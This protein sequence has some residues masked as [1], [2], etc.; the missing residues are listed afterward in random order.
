M[1]P[2]TRVFHDPLV[3]WNVEGFNPQVCFYIVYALN[4]FLHNDT[5]WHPWETSLLKALWEKE[6]L[7]VTSNFSFTHSVFYPYRELSGIFIKFKIVVSRQFQF[8]PVQNLLSGNGLN[9]MKG[10]LVTPS[11][12][13]RGKTLSD[14]CFCNI[15]MRIDWL[16]SVQRHFQQ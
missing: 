5:F 2:L 11:I 6:K 7:L 12:E 8:G 1:S 4:P 14:Y 10:V 15:Y 16:Y 13:S 3:S 9:H